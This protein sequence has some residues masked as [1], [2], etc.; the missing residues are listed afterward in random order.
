MVG[1]GVAQAHSSGDWDSA[2]AVVAPALSRADLSLANLESPISSQPAVSPAPSGGYNL[3]ASPAALPALAAAGFDLLSLANNHRS[4]CGDPGETQNA[5][6][7]QGLTPLGPGFTPLYRQINGLR[8]AFLAFDDVSAPLEVAQ[9]EDA[10]ARA[11][12]SGALVIVSIHWGWEFDPAPTA[13]QERLARN[14]AAAGATLI[15]GHHPHVLQRAE[16]LRVNGRARPTLVLY[17]LGNALFDQIAPP[18]ARRSALVIVQLDAA[19]LRQV[20]F[21]PLWID[22]PHGRITWPEADACQAI[23]RRL[24]PAIEPASACPRR[25]QTERQANDETAGRYPGKPR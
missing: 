1:R 19:G 25:E 6:Y 17:S 16:Q 21:V 2:F 18:D 15:W 9:A 14:F 22:A 24:G 4:D 3:C 13:R 23:L 12:R 10:I 20:R 11:R 5:L 7:R 8:L